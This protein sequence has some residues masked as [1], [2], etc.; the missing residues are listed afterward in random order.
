VCL[1]NIAHS[2]TNQKVKGATGSDHGQTGNNLPGQKGARGIERI[3]VEITIDWV[4]AAMGQSHEGNDAKRH[5]FRH[6]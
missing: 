4:V 2:Q 3:T 5:H 1:V 6:F